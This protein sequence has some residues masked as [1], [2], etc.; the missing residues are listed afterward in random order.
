MN[1]TKLFLPATPRLLPKYGVLPLRSARHFRP[2]QVT[3]TQRGVA[4]VAAVLSP[5]P[6]PTY[7]PR[8][9]ERNFVWKLI[10]LTVKQVPLDENLVVAF[11]R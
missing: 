11:L 5:Q 4:T 1:L 10:K 7:G 8:T 9:L 3:S 6:H 2:S